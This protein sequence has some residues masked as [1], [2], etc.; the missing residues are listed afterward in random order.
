MVSF[1][2]SVWRG[3]LRHTC[4]MC[5]SAP[6]SRMILFS[7]K[8]RSHFTVEFVPSSLHRVR[9]HSSPT[10]SDAHPQMSGRSISVD[11]STATDARPVRSKQSI[12][13]RYL[14]ECIYCVCGCVRCENAHFQ[15]RQMP[16]NQE[17]NIFR[18]SSAS[19]N[20]FAVSAK[21]MHVEQ[22]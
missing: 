15:F 8:L 2:V 20:G 6:F 17:R 16:S 21:Q 11:E 9:F 12:E 3:F 7:E 4:G 22:R 19:A 5:S 1:R 10:Q 18:I 13:F 14:R